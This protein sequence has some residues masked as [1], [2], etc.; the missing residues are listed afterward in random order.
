MNLYQPK[1]SEVFESIREDD[2]ASDYYKDEDWIEVYNEIMNEDWT[3]SYEVEPRYSSILST[4]KLKID[5]SGNITSDEG[6]PFD[7]ISQ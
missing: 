7:A 4:T 5:S 3:E 2:F 1:L 6:I